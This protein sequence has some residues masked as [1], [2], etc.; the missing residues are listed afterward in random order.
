M[1]YLQISPTAIPP[2]PKSLLYCYCNNC[3]VLLYCPVLVLQLYCI[4]YSTTPGRSNNIISNHHTNNN[5]THT[6][7][8]T[9]HTLTTPTTNT[10]LYCISFDLYSIL[11]SI[12]AGKTKT[13]E[14]CIP[15]AIPQQHSIPP[16]SLSTGEWPSAKS[17][18]DLSLAA[19]RALR[20][21]E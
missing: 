14:A 3:T 10:V 17:G 18:W 16:D 11:Y 12:P 20:T 4:Q 9:L 6:L 7:L 5:H 2:K 19:H 13:L 15:Q 8:L 21:L 1:Q